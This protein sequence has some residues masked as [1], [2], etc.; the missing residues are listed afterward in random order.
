VNGITAALTGRLGGDA[1]QRYLPNGTALA[2]FSVA[3]DDAG[4]AEG[5]APE[6]VRVTVWGHAAEDLAPRLTRGTPV[7]CEGRNKLERWDA[8]DGHE[9]SALK[10]TA[11]VVQPLGQ[12]G[13][14]VPAA[15]DGSGRRRRRAPREG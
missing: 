11:W 4:R 13:R 7:Y 6:W 3:V 8:R 9:R 12:I 15:T 2:T 14:R 5:E 10:L 1:E